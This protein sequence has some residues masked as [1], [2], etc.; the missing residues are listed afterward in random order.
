MIFLS[1]QYDEVW[2]DAPDYIANESWF[3]WNGVEYREIEEYPGYY[4]SEEGRVLST[5]GRRARF[6]KTWRGKHGHEYFYPW[7]KTE[8]KQARLLV[9]RE[10]AK[11]FIPN[12]TDGNIVRHLN[13]DPSDNRVC[14]LAWGTHKDNTADCRRNGNMYM[15]KVYCFELDETYESVT[16]AAEKLGVTKGAIVYGC[17]GKMGRVRG[18]HICYLEDGNERAKDEEWFKKDGNNKSVRAIN[19]KTGVIMNFPSRKE[20]GKALGICNTNITNVI[21]GR[22]KHAGGWRFEEGE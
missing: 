11:A 19:L 8:S 17:E 20:A 14:N 21:A 22:L 4:V 13:D 10:V 9:H 12:N 5:H 6:I 7:D 1:R 3:E 16:E 18:M 2:G 15:R